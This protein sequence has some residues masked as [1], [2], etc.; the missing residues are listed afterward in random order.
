V[1]V[2]AVFLD[3]TNPGDLFDIYN[4]V[5]SDFRTNASCWGIASS[6]FQPLSRLRIYNNLFYGWTGVLFDCRAISLSSAGP[7]EVYYNTIRMGENSSNALNV[8]HGIDIAS[9]SD[10]TKLYNN[11][12]ASDAVTDSTYLVYR[13]SGR[14]RSDRNCFNGTGSRTVVGYD[15]GAS[16]PTLT[17]WQT[18]TS[19]DANSIQDIPGFVSTTDL[20]ID[21][22]WTTCDQRASSVE[23]LDTDMDG[24]PR[25]GPFSDIGADEFVGI[26]DKLDSLVIRK[27]VGTNNVQ[28]NWEAIAGAQSWKVYRGDV[29]NFVPSEG[30]GGTWIGTTAGGV[31]SFVDS[32]PL[33]PGAP[34]KRFDKV[35]PSTVP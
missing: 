10:S 1:T 28:L 20:H 26:T 2:S 17:A 3:Q 9:S 24:E 21:G 15:N 4:N 30:T 35:R 31:R 34:I 27:Q 11:I 29:Q 18:G 32:T 16:Y 19:Q 14:L 12:L 23:W 5:I 6:T 13:S 33:S 25:G 8:H 22:Y 7:T